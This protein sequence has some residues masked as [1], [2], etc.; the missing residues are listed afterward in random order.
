MLASQ[1][2]IFFLSPIGY[3]RRSQKQAKTYQKIIMKN[4]KLVFYCLTSEVQTFSK[5][6]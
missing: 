3:S 1:T 6:L 4:G 5:E 2:K